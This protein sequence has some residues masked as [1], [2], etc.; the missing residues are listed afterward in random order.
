MLNNKELTYLLTHLP[1]GI[2][3]DKDNII[4]IT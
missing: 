3:N 2:I 4:L 1:T